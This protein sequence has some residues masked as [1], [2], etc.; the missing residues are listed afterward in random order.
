MPTYLFF[1][2]SNTAVGI[3]QFDTTSALADEKH[4]SDTTSTSLRVQSGNAASSEAPPICRNINFLLETREVHR[5]VA[6]ICSRTAIPNSQYYLGGAPYRFP[7]IAREPP[8]R[9]QRNDSESHP[10]NN[11]YWVP[12][13]NLNVLHQRDGI[14]F[15][16]EF[17]ATRALRLHLHVRRFA[18][19]PPGR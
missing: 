17:H 12:L 13:Q 2:N 6:A 14:L 1:D 5:R 15:L 3:S 18:F 19:Q 9:F 8:Y 11:D 7:G 10:S 4:V 16:S